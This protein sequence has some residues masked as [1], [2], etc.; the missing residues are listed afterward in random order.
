MHVYAGNVI[1]QP[2]KL[3]R[4]PNN[5]M[6]GKST[7]PLCGGGCTPTLRLRSDDSGGPSPQQQF[8]FIEGP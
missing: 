8:G 6:V 7:Q 5:E 1:G 2:G 4:D 3:D